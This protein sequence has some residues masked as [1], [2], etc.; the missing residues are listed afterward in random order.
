MVSFC[1]LFT[2]FPKLSK[3]GE[4]SEAKIN[5]NAH[6]STVVLKQT[7]FSSLIPCSLMLCA[8]QESYLEHLWKNFTHSAH[9]YSW[10]NRNL[11]SVYEYG[12]QLSAFYL[13]VEI[14]C[15]CIWSSSHPCLRPW[16]V[17][18]SI[19][20]GCAR[21]GRIFSLGIKGSFITFT[22]PTWSLEHSGQCFLFQCLVLALL[23]HMHKKRGL[24]VYLLR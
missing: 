13:T 5:F 4:M 23:T 3:S 1:L 6:V 19:L 15:R 11:S 20:V 9:S 21:E 18:S 12:V 2:G 16:K 14:H 17:A 10:Q 7:A 22:V 24:L 8:Y